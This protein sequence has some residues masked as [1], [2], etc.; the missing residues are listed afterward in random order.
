MKRTLQCEF[1]AGS[2]IVQRFKLA[3]ERQVNID[4][5]ACRHFVDDI[6]QIAAFE[7]ETLHQAVVRKHGDDRQTLYALQEFVALSHDSSHN[8]TGPDNDFNIYSDPNSTMDGARVP[9]T[10]RDVEPIRVVSVQNHTLYATA[11]VF[12]MFVWWFLDSPYAY[13]VE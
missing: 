12:V 9:L 7:D 3:V 8:P 4:R 1:D 2:E 10:R 5:R 11:G 6:E 13:Q